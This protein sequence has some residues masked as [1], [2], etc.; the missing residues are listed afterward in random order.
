MSG[1]SRVGNAQPGN[2]R[3]FIKAKGRQFPFGESPAWEFPARHK[4]QMLGN[5]HAGEPPAGDSLLYIKVKCR[6]IPLLL[7]ELKL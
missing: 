6:R 7:T 4:G 3:T 1:N 2:S 5:S